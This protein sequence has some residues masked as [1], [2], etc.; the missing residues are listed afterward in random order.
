MSDKERDIP[1]IMRIENQMCFSMYTAAN[2]IVRAYRPWLAD[3]DLTYLQYMVMMVLWEHQ[4]INVKA[5]SQILH[6]DSGTLTPLLKRLQSKEL[7]DRQRDE[8]DER[9]RIIVLTEKG[10][11]LYEQ[12][13]SIPNKMICKTNLPKE[14]LVTLKTICQK[15]INELDN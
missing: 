8:M 13:L 14:E 1:E 3:L 9:V 2:A 5:L 7:V 11:A 12:A 4:R 10:N 15:L 6:L